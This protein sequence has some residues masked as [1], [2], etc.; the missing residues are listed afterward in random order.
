MNIKRLLAISALITLS[1]LGGSIALAAGPYVPKANEFASAVVM[2]PDGKVLYGYKQEAPHTAAS[3]SKLVMAL[4]MLD[5]NWNWGTIVKMAAADEVGGGRLRVA[6]GAKIVLADLWQSAIG[7]SANNAAMAMARLAGPGVP[8]FVQ[9]MNTKVKSIGAKSS[10]FYDPAGMNAKNTT[11]AYDMALIARAAFKQ[12]KVISASQSGTYTFTL[13]GT[14]LTHTIKNTNAR[15][16]ADPDVY[17]TG[18][19]TGYLPE[20]MFNYAAQMSPLLEDGKSGEK[21]K[22]VVVVVLGSNS[23][24]GAMDSAK[25]LA[26]WAWSDDD[27]F[28]SSN[29]PIPTKSLY[30]GITNDEVRW[31][32]EALDV[33]PKSGFFGPLTR[34]AV[35]RFQVAQ[36]IAKSGNSGYGV[37]GPATRAKLLE[38]AP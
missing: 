19:K 29:Y 20:S 32:Q 16:L 34:L 17:L 12:S 36:G 31:V 3:L 21:K 15:L 5:R 22:D 28:K 9:K 2:R 25:R 13:A 10:L 38:L 6:V 1:S 14:T 23:T 8:A 11:T 27:N 37:V 30:Y 26:E 4:V 33:E 18:G 35:Q 24:Q 7:S